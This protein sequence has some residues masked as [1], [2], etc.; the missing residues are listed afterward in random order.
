MASS[1]SPRPRAPR[2]F[3]AVAL[4]GFTVAAIGCTSKMKDTVGAG[5]GTGG[6]PPAATITIVPDAF[7]KGMM[8]FAPDTV[9]VHVNDIVRVH[10]GDSI[11]HD[12]EGLTPGDPS[13]GPLSAGQNHDTQV[14]ATGTKTFVC[15]IAGHSMIGRVIVTP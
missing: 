5:G 6:T 12:I 15:A 2:V 10:N 13:W 4:A 7:N 1:I 8:A 11:Q 14:T 3:L 9:T